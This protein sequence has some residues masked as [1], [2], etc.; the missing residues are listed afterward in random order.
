MS[1]Q[2]NVKPGHKLLSRSIVK[3]GFLALGRAIES[4]SHFEKDVLKEIEDWPEGFSY[5]LTVMPYGPNLVM[6]KRNGVMK[7]LHVKKKEDA[8]LIVK[9]KNLSTAFKMITTQLGAHNVI[10]QNKI[11]V[12]GNVADTVKLIRVIYIAEGYLFPEI[13]NKNILKKSPK[14]TLQKHLNRI[15]I[16]TKGMILGR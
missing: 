12:I 11:G 1:I 14:M 7:M 15:H 10:A 5:N 6:E 16:L 8:N 2:T 4:A 9:I 3:A 13:L